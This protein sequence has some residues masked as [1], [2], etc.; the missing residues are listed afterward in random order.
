MLS[1]VHSVN[2][3]E[4]G[5]NHHATGRPLTKPEIVHEYNKYMGAVD[6]CDQMVAYSCFRRRTMK[7]WKKTLVIRSKQLYLVQRENKVAS[8]TEGI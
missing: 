7:W 4:I 6:R 3:V 2:E 1:S 8:T 5:R